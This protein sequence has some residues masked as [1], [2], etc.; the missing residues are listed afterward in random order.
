MKIAVMGNGIVGKSLVRI[1]DGREDMEVAYILELP[2]KC[3]EKRMVSDLQIILNDPEV[4]LVADALPSVQ[5]SFSFI[6]EA[7]NAGKHVVSSNKAALAYDLRELKE[8]A[9]CRNVKLLFEASC[10]GTIPCLKEA[11]SLSASND[12][13]SCYGIMN[14]TT[15]FILDR[16]G[17]F[18][19]DFTGALK[20]AQELGY[21]EADP[22]ADI[23]G[24]DVKNKIVLLSDTAYH[25]YVTKEFPV[26]GIGKISRQIISDLKEQG[27]TVKLLGMSV[28]QGCRYALGVAPVIIPLSSMEA[29]VPE[30][31]NLITFC[32]SNAGE[33]KLYGQGAGGL[34]TADAMTRNILSIAENSK[35]IKRFDQKLEYDP[36]LLCGKGLIGNSYER[37]SLE[38]LRKTAESSGEFFAFIPDFL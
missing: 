23:S 25:G 17:H 30:N 5:P 27:K 18:G 7:L 26:C 8:L 29:N 32:C 16:M 12:I 4:E 22:T 31:Y 1:L 24:F 37:G 20:E 14:G 6:K 38:E 28:K 19:S 33:L 34:P 10:G 35:E 2:E 15:N 13:T 21:A 9:S 36:E 3:T 11:E